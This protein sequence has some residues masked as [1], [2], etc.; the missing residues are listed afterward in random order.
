MKFCIDCKFFQKDERWVSKNSICLN[1]RIT[2]RNLVTGEYQYKTCDSQ[3]NFENSNCNVSG[4]YF[5]PKEQL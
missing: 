1:K 5:E 2:P 3:R 4:I